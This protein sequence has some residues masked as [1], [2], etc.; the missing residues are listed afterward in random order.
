MSV[1]GLIKTILVTHYR[2][3]HSGARAVIPVPEGPAS[4]SEHNIALISDQPL[5]YPAS[6]V[7]SFTQLLNYKLMH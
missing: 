4:G 3:S 2:I 7:T 1:Y 5:F 6:L